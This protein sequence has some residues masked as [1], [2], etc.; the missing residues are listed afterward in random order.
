MDNN[1]TLDEQGMAFRLIPVDSLS[2]DMLSKF[3]ALK[4]Q[5]WPHGLDE[6]KKWWKENSSAP[7]IL[8][9]IWRGDSLV[10]FVRLRDR[11]I[12]VN[13]QEISSRCITEVCVNKNMLGQNIGQFSLQHVFKILQEQFT[14]HGHL[15]CTKEQLAFYQKCGMKI[16]DRAF[17]RVDHT[18][19]YQEVAD[20]IFCCIFAPDQK[21]EITVK[22]TGTTY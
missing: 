16:A 3:C 18:Y 12:I 4:D 11:N 2:E 9:S 6:Q 15:L 21:P 22:L 1:T 19:D 13:D 20:D 17:R 5:H 7:D 10:A 14:S 8:A